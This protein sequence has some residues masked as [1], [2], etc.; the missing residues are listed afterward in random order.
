[1]LGYK[2]AGLKI[3]LLYLEK[4]NSLIPSFDSQQLKVSEVET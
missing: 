1:M 4:A 2:I 3:K